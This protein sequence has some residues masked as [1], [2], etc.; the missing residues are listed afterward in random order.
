MTTLPEEIPKPPTSRGGFPPAQESCRLECRTSRAGHGRL[1]LGTGW[2]AFSK[3]SGGSIFRRAP[4]EPRA[5]CVL[6]GICSRFLGLPALWAGQWPPDRCRAS[7]SLGNAACKAA[8][9]ACCLIGCYPAVCLDWG[10]ALGSYRCRWGGEGAVESPCQARQVSR[11][12][13]QMTLTDKRTHR[14]RTSPAQGHGL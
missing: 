11:E 2:A 10:R 1:S 8:R 5:S 9:R 6:N 13:Q 14:N 3:S 4:G 12:S 7:W